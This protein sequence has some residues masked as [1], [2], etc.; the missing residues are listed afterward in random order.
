MEENHAAV[1]LRVASVHQ[2]L[3]STAAADTAYRQAV[4]HDTGNDA[5]VALARWLSLSLGEP[6]LK[7]ALALLTTVVSTG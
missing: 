7:E 3:G 4:A 5:K 2:H 6:Q 1:W